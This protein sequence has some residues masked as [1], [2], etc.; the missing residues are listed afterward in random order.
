MR[1]ATTLFATRRVMFTYRGLNPPPPPTSTPYLPFCFLLRCQHP[2]RG[3]A[4]VD[5]D[6]R[7]D[8]FRSGGGS[9]GYDSELQ[10]PTHGGNQEARGQGGMGRDRPGRE[11]GSE[12]VYRLQERHP[13]MKTLLKL[14]RVQPSCITFY[15]LTAG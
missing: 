7:S 8:R 11:A 1:L 9:H 4:C 6:R 14:D 5:V 10:G 15:R 2:S 12:Q 13:G 3:A